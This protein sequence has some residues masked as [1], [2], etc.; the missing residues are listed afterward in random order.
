MT[1]EQSIIEQALASVRKALLQSTASSQVAPQEQLLRVERE[2][3]EMLDELREDRPAHDHSGLGR[4][5]VDSWPLQ[6]ELTDRVCAAVRAYST[7]IG[8]RSA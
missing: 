8:I 7:A 6:H 5:V 2:L 3:S 4:M 1:K